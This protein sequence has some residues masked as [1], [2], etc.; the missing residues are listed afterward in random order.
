MLDYWNKNL[1]D[2]KPLLQLDALKNLGIKT[3]G[4]TVEAE[5]YTGRQTCR[6]KPPKILDR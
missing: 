4:I 5:T 6:T 3:T 2:K 1:K